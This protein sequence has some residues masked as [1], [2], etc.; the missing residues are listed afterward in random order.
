MSNESDSG[1]VFVV[2][3]RPLPGVDAIK[4]LRQGLKY[5]LRRCGLRCISI[6]QKENPDARRLEI[7]D[8]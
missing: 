4:A 8:R 5:L 2:K 3:L 1:R 6:E 7:E